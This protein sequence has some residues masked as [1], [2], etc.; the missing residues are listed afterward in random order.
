[1]VWRDGS[2]HWILG[3]FQCF[4]D[5]AGNPVRLAGVNIDV[6]DRKM[7]S[8]ALAQRQAELSEA[9]RLAHIGSWHWDA[10]TDVIRG[11][12]E[13]LRIY[14]FDPATQSMPNFRDQRGCC[15]PVEDWETVN[16]AVQRSLET[17]EGYELDVRAI[18]DHTPVWVTTRGEAV[19]D[20]DD[21]IVGLRGTVQDI[22]LRKQVE[23]VLKASLRE[24][25]VL[26]KEIHRRVKNNMQVISSL[27]D[28]QSGRGVP[29]SRIRLRG[30][31]A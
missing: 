3:R 30:S 27:V 24:K 10:K 19:R 2:V 1:V 5:D 25:E 14:G 18:R 28:L 11:S 31:G 6:T 16:A 17:G 21:R 13:L 4:K 8:E 29:E 9:Q 15:Y 20:A 23:E 22:T 12:D 7:A 26:L